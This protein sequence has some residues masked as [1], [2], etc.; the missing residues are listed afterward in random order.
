[1]R[2]DGCFEIVSKPPV[3]QNTHPSLQCEDESN[4]TD[5][6]P[7]TRPTEPRRTEG[8][9]RQIPACCHGGPADA[10]RRD[11]P[12]ER[13]TGRAAHP[14][15]AGGHDRPR[16][17]RQQGETLRV[18]VAPRQGR[19]VRRH[20]QRHGLPLEQRAHDLR[21][22]Q[23]VRHALRARSQER[24]RTARPGQSACRPGARR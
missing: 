23:Q 18:R 2:L 3:N 15:Q 4:D 5:Q 19:G 12:P 16:I 10:P 13:R 1:M 24:K 9:H 22:G 21:G 6:S 14:D 17:R 8:P 7:Q 11:A 20:D